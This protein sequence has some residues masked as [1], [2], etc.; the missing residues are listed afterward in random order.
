MSYTI[1]IENTGARFPAEENE[2]ILDA[3]LRAGHIIPYSCRGGT[4]GS[5]AGKVVEGHIDYPQGEPPALNPTE[6][7]VGQA[8]FCQAQPRSD[9]VIEVREVRAAD[10]IQPRKLPV[11]VI[12]KEQLAH[13]VVRL[14]L[15]PPGQQRLQFLAGQY[16]DILLKDGRRRAFSLANAPHDDEALELHVRH[17]EGG[18]FTAFVMTEM[19]EKALLRL[20]G[21]HGQ[22]YLREDSERPILM[23]AGGTG[24]APLKGMLE[25][26]FHHGV[27]RPIHLYWGVRAKRDLYLDDLPRQWAEQHPNFHYT[28]V[29]SEPQPEDAWEGR[30]GLVHNI[31]LQDHPRLAGYD[32]YLS[33]PPAMIHAATRDFSAHGMQDD[34][35]FSDAFEFAADSRPGGG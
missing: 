2:N 9:L 28:P 13:D 32:L 11:R 17:V 21:P 12:R 19:K 35:V 6:K 24:F 33:G 5:C 26:A 22:F 27:Q 7:A 10:D 4:C 18:E 20:E 15:Q 23:M 1:T 31:L 30:T 16:V 3:A 8:L 34:R 14:Y 29:L 25:H